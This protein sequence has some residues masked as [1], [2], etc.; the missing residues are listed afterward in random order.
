MNKLK[1]W[2]LWFHYVL[3]EA[4]LVGFLHI[5]GQHWIHS[6]TQNLIGFYIVIAGGD[7]LVHY[8]LRKM[9]GWRNKNE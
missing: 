3:L 1:D 7:Q 4:I 8:I 9:T 2:R 5:N 6:S